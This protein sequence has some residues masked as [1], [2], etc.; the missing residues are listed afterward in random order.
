MAPLYRQVPSRAFV[1]E[2]TEGDAESLTTHVFDS[3]ICSSLANAFDV[4]SQERKYVFPY[5][6]VGPPAVGARYGKA[7]SYENQRQAVCRHPQR[8][9][10]GSLF[11][12]RLH[13]CWPPSFATQFA[14][15]DLLSQP[16][17]LQH[18]TTGGGLRSHESRGGVVGV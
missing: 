18:S 16:P 14:W 10:R 3:E 11:A 1:P 6:L 4:R 9:A 15:K 12:N 17:Y 13:T 5:R 7:R 8:P 2:V